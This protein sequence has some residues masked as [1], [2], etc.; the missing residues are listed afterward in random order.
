M[1]NMGHAYLALRNYEKATECYETLRKL[2]KEDLA[3]TYLRRLAD[4]KSE[5][6]KIEAQKA[7]LEN[8]KNN[9]DITKLLKKF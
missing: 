5:R 6:E 2:G 3:K 1:S 7:K 9:S 8:D 4:Q